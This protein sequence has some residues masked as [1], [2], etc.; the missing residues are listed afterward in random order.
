[1][2]NKLIYNKITEN[3]RAGKKM[4]AVLIDPDKY[5]GDK[6]VTCI[7]EM[8][9]VQPDFILVGGSL[10]FAPTE[11]T[12]EII[13]NQTDIPVILFPGNANQFSG[14]ADA[15]FLLSL[16]SGRN[17]EYL[18]GQHVTAA[19]AIYHSKIEIISVGYMLIES[20]AKTSV[21]Y[22]SNTNPIPSD[23]TE[24]AVA[25]ALAGEMLGNKLIYLEAGSGATNHVPAKM[26]STLKK[27]LFVPLIVG[28]GI[29]TVENI[30]E[31]LSAGADIVVIGNAL[32]KDLALMES[33]AETVKKFK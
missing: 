7:S 14:N 3:F 18:I 25:T 13:K 12:I 8:K 6:L 32:E 21:E 26:I 16:I 22:I 5:I 19:P 24:I 27:H 30:E 33:F 29:R 28:G 20:G 1:M 11:K 15:L 2:G 31:V 10:T 17:P 23:K 9:K 4:L